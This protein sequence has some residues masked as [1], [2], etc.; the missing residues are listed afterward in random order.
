MTKAT[1]KQAKP[2]TTRPIFAK[3][4]SVNAP[5][6]LDDG[7][8][9]LIVTSPPYWGKRQ[10]GDDENEVGK[11]G[12][13][14]STYRAHLDDFFW[15]AQ[16]VLADDGAI[17]FNIGDTA[18]GSGG[19]GGD[20]THPNGTRNKRPK[21]KQG[22]SGLPKGTLGGI[23]FLI[24]SAA[25]ESD[26]L[27]R[28]T[29]VWHKKAMTGTTI[30]S[31]EDTNH[32]KRPKS[33]WEPIFMFTKQPKI[34]WFGDQKT[35]DVWSFD[36]ARRGQSGDRMG[37]SDAPFPFELPRRCI[38]LCTE[39]GDVVLD[40][41]SGGGTTAIMASRMGRVGVG[42]DLYETGASSGVRG[43]VQRMRERLH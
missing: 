11:S 13:S 31:R 3:H 33:A 8:V 29:I 22:K 30:L 4:D 2:P 23:P 15:Y 24:A 37:G 17:F 35:S 39:Y 27:L 34:K 43:R 20:Y 41:F 16:R 36:V 5:W 25:I 7:S 19:A 14:L 1:P 26:W 12:E 18:I 9:Q 21:F 40:P 28:S 6:P 38:E 10:Y 42:L 32:I